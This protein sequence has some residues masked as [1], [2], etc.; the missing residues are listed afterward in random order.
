MHKTDTL[1]EFSDLLIKHRFQAHAVKG[2]ILFV[3]LDLDEAV[4]YPALD[5]LTSTVIKNG[6]TV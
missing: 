4:D 2:G 3:K 6:G 1:N 5:K